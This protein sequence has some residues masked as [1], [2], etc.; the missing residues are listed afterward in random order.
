MRLA[1]LQEKYSLSSLKI[2]KLLVTAGVYEPVKSTSSYYVVKRLHDA[3]NT[4]EEIVRQTGL[5]KA[6]VNACIPYERGA[7]ELDRFGVGISGNAA[8]KRKQRSLKEAKKRNARTILA[9]NMSD[10][11]LWHTLARHQGE[12]FIATTGQRFAIDVVDQDGL[13]ELVISEPYHHDKAELTI[14]KLLHHDKAEL[15]TSEPLHHDQAELVITTIPHQGILHI[16]QQAVLDAFHKAIEEKGG[17]ES[18]LGNYDEYLRP[19]FIYL[20]ILGG[21][22]SMVTTRREAPKPE[23]CSCCGRIGAPLYKVSSFSDLITLEEQF[24]NAERETWTDDQKKSAEVAEKIMVAERKRYALQIEAAKASRVATAFDAEG[25]RWFCQLCAQTIFYALSEGDAPY[26]GTKVN[27]RALSAESARSFYEDQL[28]STDE[29]WM[30]KYGTIFQN[31]DIYKAGDT[32]GEEHYFVMLCRQ[33]GA[34][35]SFDALEVHRLTKAGKRAVNNT[36][37]DYEF[38]HLITLVEGDDE[39]Q[40]VYAGLTFMRSITT[41]GTDSASGKK[42]DRKP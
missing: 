15:T 13:A 23:Y 27:C 31:E 8:R 10:V 1:D 42:C 32:D 3:G 14:S 36:D 29:R 25:E 7:K 19:V 22:R 38:H 33:F 16:S 18:G 24:R 20:G 28:A 39:R 9:D 21:D 35:L 11:A 30:D 6:V 12:R 40:R 5:F 34:L 41:N 17:G 2:Q 4:M 37:T 26:V